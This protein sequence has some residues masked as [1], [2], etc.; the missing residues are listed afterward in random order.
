MKILFHENSLNLRGSSQAL[1]DYAHYNE[2][3]LGNESV[4]LYDSQGPESDPAAVQKF[5]DRFNRVTSYSDD[6]DRRIAEV[7]EAEAVDMCYFIKDGRVDGKLAPNTP[8][9]VHTIFQ[10]YEPHGEVYAYVSE[11]LAKYR[12]NGAYPYVP[13]IVWLPEARETWRA[14]LDIPEDA[15]VFG[16]YGGFQT[17]D[18]KFVKAGIAR[19]LA[20]DPAIWF[21]FVNTQ[22]FIEHPRVR[23]LDAITDPFQKSGFIQTCDAMVHARRRGES[24]GLA[25]CEFLFHGKP[26]LAWR[27]G[28]DGNH[29]VVLKNAPLYSNENSFYRLAQQVRHGELDALDWRDMVRPFAPDAVMQ[30]FDQVF[31]QR[32]CGGGPG[33]KMAKFGINAGYRLRRLFG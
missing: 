27:G 32:N 24:F 3:I 2:T 13:H 5:Q 18:L 8:N 4:V 31:I 20:D 26:V 6:F 12:T 14:R 28:K 7:C 23:F 22:P 30:R 19:L 25:I 1:F 21:L 10:R 33:G 16:R 29:R 17:F 9:A 11:W 15:F